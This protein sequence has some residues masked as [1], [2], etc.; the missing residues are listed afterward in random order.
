[1]AY[2]TGLNPVAR[3]EIERSNRSKGTKINVRELYSICTIPFYK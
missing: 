3:N 1:M 2:T